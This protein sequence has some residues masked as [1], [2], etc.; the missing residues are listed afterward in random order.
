M[1]LE[2]KRKQRE[3]TQGLIRR[4]SQRVRRSGILRQARKIRF[5]KKAKSDEAKKKAALRKEQLK[6][7]YQRSEKMGELKERKRKGHR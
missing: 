1:P 2:V 6:R 5:Q 3:S 7:E 4:F